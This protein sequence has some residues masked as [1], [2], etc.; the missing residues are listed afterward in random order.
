MDLD[1]ST[2]GGVWFNTFAATSSTLAR[3]VVTWD[4]VPE[5]GTNGAPVFTFQLQLVSDGT[6]T[7]LYDDHV[8]N[9]WHNVL[10]G[11]TQGINAVA[12]PVDFSAITASS[13]H[14]SGQNPTVH[15]EQQMVCDLAGKS[16]LFLPA[17]AG[18]I[19]M[20]RPGCVLAGS[21]RFG[22][23]CPSPAVAYELF[24]WG[25]TIDLSN[26]AIDFLPNPGGG[27]TAVPTTGFF[28]GHTNAI[29]TG[30]D[31]VTGPFTMPFTFSFPGGST[32]AIDISSN[33]F[34][35]LSTGNWNSRCCQG[36]V[37]DFLVDPASIA[38]LWEDLNPSQGGNVYFDVDP[39]NTEVHI[40]WLNVPEYWNTGSCTA[41]ITLRSNGS[42]R[43]SWQSVANQ[44]N[45]CLVGFS[46]GNG[47]LDPGPLDFSA[48][49]PFT[50]GSGGIPLSLSAQLG[51]RPVL[52]TT[53][54]MEVTDFPAGSAFA[55]LV[56]GFNRVVPAIDLTVYGMPGCNQN[57]S[58]DATRFFALTG[59]PAPVGF[60][61]PNN[62]AFSGF[63]LEAQV[64]TLSPGANPLGAL[65]SNGLEMKFGL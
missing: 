12:N 61:V 27:Y 6:F 42:F 36:T 41:Q 17:G 59:N 58:L 28:T 33:G 30:D 53:F 55:I 18:Y 19:V 52:G 39:S 11:C 44:N 56:V 43:L 54:G 34:I 20:D 63:L 49:L 37:Y 21:E 50:T 14:I 9:Q 45:D 40:T 35:W 31:V 57:V 2:A 47:A 29:A 25:G 5:Y 65:T 16:Y 1:P 15:E 23:G 13:P 48:A 64:L 24:P 22:R 51:A 3:A 26:T 7:F 8:S 62:A 32:N 46:Q 4:Q 60:V 10:T 38:V